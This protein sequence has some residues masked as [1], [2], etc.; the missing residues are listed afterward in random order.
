MSAT[1]KNNG[2]AEKYKNS[3]IS[4]AVCEIR[5]VADQ[6]WDLAVPGLIYERLRNSFPKR[7]MT[8]SIEGT[9][10]GGTTRLAEIEKVQ[11]LQ[12]DEK[13][14]VHVGKDLVSASRLSPYPGWEAFRPLIL[15]AV[16]AYRSVA[17]PVSLL[18]VGLRYLNQVHFKE[19]RVEL[20]DFFEFY[21]FVGHR[22]PRDHGPFFSG[23]QFQYEGGRDVLRLQIST[24]EP[25]PGHKIG[26]LLDLDYILVEASKVALQEIET[27][28]DTAHFRVAETFEA[29][30]TEALR[31][32]FRGK[33]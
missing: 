1:E 29:C 20:S 11:F 14:L 3:P 12:D 2:T 7:R 31:T 18:R 4:E 15:Q 9:I 32:R 10:V 24:A 30:L 33:G 25:T 21:P 26:V 28:L 22:L 17:S 27:W 6:P 5:F 8:K 19:E 13:A 16:G 23:V